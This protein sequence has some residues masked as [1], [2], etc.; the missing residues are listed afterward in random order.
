MDVER[1]K[2]FAQRIAAL[3]R[4][5][6]AYNLDIRFTLQ[7]PGPQP[8][9]EARMTFHQGRHGSAGTINLIVTTHVGDFPEE[10]D[11]AA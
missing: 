4:E 5:F 2:A 11:D 10:L 8:F 1:N 6:D 3:C 7:E 9:E